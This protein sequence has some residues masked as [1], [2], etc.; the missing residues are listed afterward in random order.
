MQQLPQ[1]KWPALRRFFP[2]DTVGRSFALAMVEGN[3]TGHVY[4]DDLDRPRTAVVAPTCDFNLV[5]GD[6]G[7]AAA[8]REIRS[9]LAAKLAPQDGYVLVFGT[10]PEWQHTLETL[11]SD[12]PLVDHPCRAVY[13]LDHSQFAERHSGWRDRVAEGYQVV[14]YNLD[15]AQNKGLP[16]FWGSA[17]AFLARG[18]GYAAMQG[19]TSVSRCH[20]V[21]VGDGEAEISIDTNEAHRRKGLAT[22]V[23]CA[24]IEACFGRGLEPAWSCWADNVPSRSLAESLGFVLHAE[25]PG[26]VVQVK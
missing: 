6:A 22:A 19:D 15:L 4:V 23:A 8:N 16:A 10:S 5:A 18:V 17:D 7:N 3:H 25:T 21:I 1:S 20:T 13:H 26:L 14:P 24:F 2:Q 11:F 9:L 12:A